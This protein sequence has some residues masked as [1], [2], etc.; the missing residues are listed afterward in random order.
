MIEL[1]QKIN[2]DKREKGHLNISDTTL[3]ITRKNCG[4]K[5]N[6][7][8]KKKKKYKA[9]FKEKEGILLLKRLHVI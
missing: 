2:D 3:K 7:L 8:Q 6:T 5:Q 9:F 4:K 1:W